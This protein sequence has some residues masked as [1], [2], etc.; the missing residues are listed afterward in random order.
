MA[1]R[2][3]SF[4]RGAPALRQTRLRY[5]V[6]GAVLGGLWF[7]ARGVPLWEHGAQTLV[8]MIALTTLQFVVRVRRGQRAAFA[9]YAR[10][11][12][13]KVA[14]VAVAVIAQW[15]LSRWTSGA[16]AMVAVGMAILVAALGPALDARAAFDPMTTNN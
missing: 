16:D 14:L 15:L 6:A 2:S 9:G 8:V 4:D 11:V 1:D 13:T 7:I 5:L 3:T 10:L 12:A